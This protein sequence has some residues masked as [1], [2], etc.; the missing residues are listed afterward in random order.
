MIDPNISEA[1]EKAR[2]A[3]ELLA[4]IETESV[5][6]DRL[7]EAWLTLSDAQRAIEA[8]VIAA[9]GEDDDHG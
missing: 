3:A 4:A 1:E 7:D 6:T 8:A 2:Q 5:S 9:D